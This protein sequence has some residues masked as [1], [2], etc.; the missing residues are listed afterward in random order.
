[1][2]FGSVTESSSTR[3]GISLFP[4][5]VLRPMFKRFKIGYDK[6]N[7]GRESANFLEIKGAREISQEFDSFKE[8]PIAL[9][10]YII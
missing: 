7:E 4:N 9:L 10:L 3:W 1:M 8:G 2:R 5:S 6:R